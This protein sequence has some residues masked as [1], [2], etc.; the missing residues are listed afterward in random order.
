MW[1][2]HDR[3]KEFEFHDGQQIKCCPECTHF[4][5]ARE[6]VLCAEY[7]ASLPVS[8]V[9]DWKLLLEGA[10]LGEY[11]GDN[12]QRWLHYMGTTYNLEGNPHIYDV[13]EHV[14]DEAKWQSWILTTTT[15][16]LKALYWQRRIDARKTYTMLDDNEHINEAK[17]FSHTLTMPRAFRTFC[18]DCVDVVLSNK[19]PFVIRMTKGV[20]L[21]IDHDCNSVRI[22]DLKGNLIEVKPL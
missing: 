5:K 7:I 2:F 9:R 13:P 17:P 11:A 6:A 15:P 8:E 1:C 22:Y 12:Q 16:A 21:P 18:V 14:G 4:D 3:L 19:K 20:Y 10:G